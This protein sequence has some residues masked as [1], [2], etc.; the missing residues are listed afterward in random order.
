MTSPAYL[1]AVMDLDLSKVALG[2]YLRLYH[3]SPSE[4]YRDALS[5]VKWRPLKRIALANAMRVSEPTIKRAISDLLA[6]GYVERKRADRVRGGTG[7][8]GPRLYRLVHD[9]LDALTASTDHS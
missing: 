7:G 6:A 1:D 8:S 4:Q 9:R 3:G 2:L 5:P